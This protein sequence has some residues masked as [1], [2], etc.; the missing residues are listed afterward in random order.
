MHRGYIANNK[1]LLVGRI[2]NDKKLASTPGPHVHARPSYRSRTL[3]RRR[4]KGEKRPNE[5]N[6]SSS[7]S[8]PRTAAR[9]EL[10]AATHA[11]LG[12]LASYTEENS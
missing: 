3:A 10:A 8:D 5:S 2:Y 11:R 9:A 1:K 6:D 12:Y 7:C 4:T